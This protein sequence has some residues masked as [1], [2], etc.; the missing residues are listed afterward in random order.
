MYGSVFAPQPREKKFLANEKC[1]EYR[2]KTLPI[3]LC[4]LHSNFSSTARTLS[5]LSSSSGRF[6]GN[7]SIESRVELRFFAIAHNAELC[8]LVLCKDCKIIKVFNF[9]FPLLSF[10]PCCELEK[11]KRA[12]ALVNVAVNRSTSGIVCSPTIRTTT[13]RASSW[14]G[15]CFHRAASAAAIH[16][17]SQ[18]FHFHSQHTISS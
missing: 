10:F 15:F 4:K 7:F 12:G 8:E 16:S 1:I 17:E 6:G 13:A 9:F 14:I 5:T 3:N 18:H 11:C 2:M